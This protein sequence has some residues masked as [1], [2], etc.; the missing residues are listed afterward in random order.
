MTCYV[1]VGN[2]CHDNVAV[3]GHQVSL[4]WPH[5]WPQPRCFCWSWCH[6][7]TTTVLDPFFW[8]HQG[9]PVPE[10][11]S[12]TLCCKGRL[13]EA[14]TETI[15]L[16]ATPSGLTIAQLHHPPNREWKVC[17]FLALLAEQFF[18]KM[19]LQRVIVIQ[20]SISQLE[21]AQSDLYFPLTLQKCYDKFI[22][23]RPSDHYFRSVCW[24]GCLC[25]V[26]LSRL[27]SGFDQTW[28]CVICLGLVVSPRI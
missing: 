10:E 19:W 6:K 22:G 5:S 7:H 9:E 18:F 25:R 1:T 2:C 15:R 20:H 13:T 28:T 8:D 27:W 3:G 26:F 12:W 11:N 17:P 23:S 21:T 24:F 4:A 16:S 14:D